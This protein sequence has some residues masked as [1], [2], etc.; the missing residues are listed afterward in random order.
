MEGLSTNQ[1]FI[2]EFM[3]EESN[4]EE[5]IV[6]E[7]K[8]ISS[9]HFGKVINGSLNLRLEPSKDAQ[10][11]KILPVDTQVNYKGIKEEIDGFVKVRVEEFDEDGFVMDEFIAWD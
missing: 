11:I 4:V 9:F 3:V 1:E 5:E 7:P 2:E 8:E 10:I 6:E